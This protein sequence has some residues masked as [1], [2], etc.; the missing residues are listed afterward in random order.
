MPK[1]SLRAALTGIFLMLGALLTVSVLL[2]RYRRVRDAEPTFAL[3]GLLLGVVG[4][5]GTTIHDD[6]RRLRSRQRTP[7][8]DD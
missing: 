7:S 4:A 1:D 6:P 2:G 8:P 5:F 3:L